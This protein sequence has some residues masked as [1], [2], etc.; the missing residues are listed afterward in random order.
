MV[1]IE[2]KKQ[3]FVLLVVGGTAGGVD[4]PSEDAVLE[5]GWRISPRINHRICPNLTRAAHETGANT[6]MKVY[7]ALA[8]HCYNPMKPGSIA[9]HLNM[10]KRGFDGCTHGCLLF[11]LFSQI[12]ARK[13]RK[14]M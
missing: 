2:R 1:V 11:S 5:I 8:I 6:L 3:P 10:S 4:E 12:E 7:A 13:L 9:T 14:S